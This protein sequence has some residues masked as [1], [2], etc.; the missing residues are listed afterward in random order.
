[1]R[2]RWLAVLML[3]FVVEAASI[4]LADPGTDS[5]GVS[6]ASADTPIPIADGTA[7]TDKAGFCAAT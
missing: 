2:A 3:G 7:N 6:A 4:L 1:M 5:G